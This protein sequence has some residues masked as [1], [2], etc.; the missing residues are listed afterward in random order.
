MSLFSAL[1]CPGWWHWWHSAVSPCRARCLC[2]T[3]R[4]WWCWTDTAGSSH[5]EGNTTDIMTRMV[6]TDRNAHECGAGSQMELASEILRLSHCAQDRKARV[7][8]A[9]LH[10]GAGAGWHR[11]HW[12]HLLDP[13]VLSGNW[14]MHLSS[15]AVKP[16]DVAPFILLIWWCFCCQKAPC[17][18]QSSVH[19]SHRTA[20]QTY[21]DHK[22]LPTAFTL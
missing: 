13:F 17:G 8:A 2:W 12:K 19:T 9:L 16:V 11:S 6:Y 5:S 3:A 4:S 10:Y 21:T 18:W 7:K 1:P 22:K 14:C 15:W 20:S